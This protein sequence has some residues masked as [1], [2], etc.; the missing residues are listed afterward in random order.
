MTRTNKGYG[1]YMGTTPE[2]TVLVADDN[3][4]NRALAR[5]TL[6]DQGYRVVL[7][8]DGEQA[9]A[10]FLE[11]APD[12]VLLDVRMPR[13]DGPDACRR[14]RELPGGGDVPVV[15]VTALRDVDTFDRAQL[16]GADDFVS[17]PYR[18][19]ELL[20]RVEAALRLR[21]L[22]A[23][24]SE[25]Y[26]QLKH[27][28]DHLQ[29]LQLQKEQLAAFLVH[30]FKNPVNAIDLLAEILLR[31]PG[32]TER[33]RRTASKIHEETRALMRM[34]TNLLDISKAD[35]GRLAPAREAVDLSAIVGEVVET[36]QGRARS[37]GVTLRAEVAAPA[38]SADPD[39]VRRLIENLVDNAIR[40]APEG[41]E[42]RVHAG[43]DGGG[44]VQLRVTDAGP[45]VPPD[46]R[47]HVF[48]RFF[49]TGGS[50]SGGGSNRGLGLAF[51]KLAAEAHGGAIWIE[52][53]GP[54]AIF[55]VRLPHVD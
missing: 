3:P 15:F 46:Q 35:E 2:A 12:C 28:R 48:E 40:H 5:A 51:C 53:A 27:Q 19:S 39:L 7:A 10:A 21:R 55:C 13:L 16:S 6:E 33:S 18:P 26:A 29:R 20:G 31:D 49:Q 37:A 45:G 25:L 44:T 22:A 50:S 52:D 17:K 32:A 8:E 36:L 14:I 9:V 24:R 34:I 47:E 4:E 38:M 41:S 43:P 42:V 1:T 11:H 30:D 54:G 23:E